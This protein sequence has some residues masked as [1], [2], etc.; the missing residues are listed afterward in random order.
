MGGLSCSSVCP[1]FKVLIPYIVGKGKLILLGLPPKK[2]MG[3]R[4][5]FTGLTRVP[6]A[7]DRTYRGDHS[8]FV[9]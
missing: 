2:H 6:E 3:A 8:S 9:K 4:S 1:E 7:P 5:G